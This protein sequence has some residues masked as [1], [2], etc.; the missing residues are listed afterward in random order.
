MNST[1]FNESVL[2]MVVS[3]LATSDIN[4]FFE[5]KPTDNLMA[6]ACA[7]VCGLRFAEEW[8]KIER[9]NE[10][11]FRSDDLS[12]FQKIVVFTPDQDEIKKF[13]YRQC[14]E[15]DEI[16]MFRKRL[17]TTLHQCATVIDS[18]IRVRG[19]SISP[20]VMRHIHGITI[21]PTVMR[22]MIQTTFLYCVNMNFEVIPEYILKYILKE[23]IIFTKA[24]FLLIV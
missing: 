5:C 6:A 22:H 4:I 14:F 15:K 11:C 3:Y 17:P 12:L 20:T 1:V 23:E 7:K 24:L 2:F 10:T 9:N 21:S 16:F 18:D 19:I 8:K 13:I